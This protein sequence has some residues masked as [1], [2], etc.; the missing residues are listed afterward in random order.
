[1]LKATST[2]KKRNTNLVYDGQMDEEMR[3]WYD[4][5]R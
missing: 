4:A 1:L 5:H 3:A 2:A